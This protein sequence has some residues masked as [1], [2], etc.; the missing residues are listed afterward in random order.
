MALS[1]SSWSIFRL[2]LILSWMMLLNKFLFIEILGLGPIS[3][4]FPL[5]LFKLLIFS[6]LNLFN[7]SSNAWESKDFSL[8]LF[9]LLYLFEWLLDLEEGFLLVFFF[10]KLLFDFDLERLRYLW[11]D[12]DLGVDDDLDEFLRLYFFFFLSLDK[13]LLT[14]IL[15]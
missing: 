13:L 4:F 14:L 3:V 8:E 10:L 5:F 12:L 2:F 1:I 11:F 7:L 6:F 15:S 9:F